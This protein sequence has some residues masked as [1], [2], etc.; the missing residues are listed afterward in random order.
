VT[1]RAPRFTADLELLSRVDVKYVTLPGWKSDISGAR[2]FEELPENCRRYVE[3]IED[4]VGVKIRWIGVGPVR[5]AMIE[6]S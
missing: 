4:F 3:F 6:R 1:D 5:E 2:T